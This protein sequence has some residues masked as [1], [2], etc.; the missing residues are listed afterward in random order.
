M[1]METAR[2][3]QAGPRPG[4]HWRT[5]EP[6]VAVGVLGQPGDDFDAAASENSCQKSAWERRYLGKL[7]A[8][9]F[10]IATLAGLLGFLLRFENPSRETKL[11]YLGF[12]ACLPL[13]WMVL[14][15]ANRAYDDRF[16]YVGSEETRR[17]FRSGLMLIAAV[18]F[19]AYAFQQNFSRGYMLGSFPLLIGG[20][21]IGRYG[22]RK[23]LHR[24]RG[25]GE[26]MD[27]TI[28]V[29]HPRPAA[30]MT[31]RLRRQRYHGLDVVAA[32]LPPGVEKAAQDIDAGLEFCVDDPVSVVERYGARVVVVLSCPEID[33]IELRRL[34]WR[35]EST[36]AELLVAPAL[37]DVTGPRTSVR[38]A[39]GLP[40]LHVEPPELS[41][42]R[43]IAKATLDRSAAAVGL[44]L[45]AP[46]LLLITLMIRV[47]D[48]EK[49][50][51]RQ[52]RV[53]YHGKEFVLLK[54]RTMPADAEDGLES[55]REEN[56]HDSVLFK[57]KRDPRITKVG[58]YLRRRSLDELPQLINVLRG[59]MSLVGPRPPLPEEVSA[60]HPDLRRR[61]AV[62]PGMTGLWQVSGRADLSWEESMHLD[63]HYVE[64][65]SPALD[66][67]ILLKTVRA[68]VK[69]NGAY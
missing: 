13:I 54:F 69:A 68:V 39:S 3:S 19:T 22:L 50:I 20:T 58:S 6:V 64:N 59:E 66:F 15:A 31:R 34:S 25:T 24:Q 37:I 49:A 9:D 33:G 42:F 2:S 56:E 21:A 12:A 11:R 7:L 41:G 45:L 23:A 38:L 14:V 60:Y 62:R 47:D 30:E 52:T 53:G 48:H 46:V 65:W 5:G 4:P 40:L 67:M 16:L 10:G 28:I 17:V 44:V 43:M 36:G 55:L 18:S 35:L 1:T 57:M 32:C 63:L 61:L 51:F 27:R 26:C 8:L 29:G